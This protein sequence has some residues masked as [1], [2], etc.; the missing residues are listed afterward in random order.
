VIGFAHRGAASSRQEENTLPAFERA[1]SL[2]ARGLETDV[3]LT[4]DGVPVALHLG[5]A[6]RRR[7]PVSQLRY[8][9]LPRHVPSLPDVYERC[10]RDFELS[11]DMGAPQAIDAVVQVAE[12]YR[13][14]D[15][16]WLTYWSLPTL[17]RWRLRW[18]RLHLV[19]PTLP[20]LPGRWNRLIAQLAAQRVDAVNVHHR[21]CRREAVQRAQ[22]EGLMVFAWG[23]RG[24]GSLQRVLK[25]EVDGV[26]CDDVESMVKLT[27]G[28]LR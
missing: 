25:S 1:L 27:G 15:R 24:A 8:D 16:L 17:E 18:P 4:A 10:G 5:L 9:Q 20:L 2:G 19:Y 21:F 26:Y 22:R 23:I 11:L 13:A 28:Y 6:L 7:L 12:S 3:G 14:A